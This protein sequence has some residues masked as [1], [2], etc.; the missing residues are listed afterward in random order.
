MNFFDLFIL[1]NVKP[2]LKIILFLPNQVASK[3]KVLSL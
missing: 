2:N 3:I 1:N